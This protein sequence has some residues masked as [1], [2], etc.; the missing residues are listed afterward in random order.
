MGIFLGGIAMETVHITFEDACVLRALFIT[1]VASVSV[2]QTD[3]LIGAR[4]A[5]IDPGEGSLQISYRGRHALRVW[6]A[7]Q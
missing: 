4:L 6:D 7:T 2:A 1:G 5:W 3:R